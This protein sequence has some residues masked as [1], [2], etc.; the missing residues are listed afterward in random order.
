MK[1]RCLRLVGALTAL[2]A[3]SACD[4]DPDALSP[5]FNVSCPTALQGVNAPIE[6][7]FSGEVDPSTI[8][9]SNIVVSDAATG[10]ELPGSLARAGTGSTVRFTASDPL[11]FDTL[12]TVRFQNI[13]PAAGG[14]QLPVTICRIQ[15]EL[16]PIRELFWRRLPEAGGQPLLGAS[17]ADTAPNA[18]EFVISRLGVLYRRDGGNDVFI[19]G[20][21]RPDRDADWTVAAS[22]PYLSAG[23]DVDFVDRN[24]GFASFDDVRHSAG[25]VLRTRD[26]GGT[27]DT[28]VT[29]PNALTN[30]LLFRRTAGT[31][32]NDIFGML[33]GGSTANTGIRKYRPA[34]NS[35]SLVLASFGTG[36]GSDVDF[37][38]DTLQGV[39]STFGLRTGNLDIRGN[40]FRSSN[41]GESWTV[42]PGARATENVV[43]YRGTA[44]RN[45][46][47]A[48]VVGGNGFVGRLDVGATALAPVVVDPNLV[49]LDTLNVQAL[50]FNDI[51]FARDND[52][53][54]WIVG[55]RQIGIVGGLPQYQ[56][57][58]YV[59]RDG[60]VTWTRQGVLGA[61]QFGA[62]FPALNRL[63]VA[64]SRQALIVGDAGVVL[65][66]NP[67]QP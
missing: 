52:L 55:A 41:G 53:V 51:A 20:D 15:T 26:A 12:I 3:V 61:D 63:E 27:F 10:I 39:V 28:L 50:I 56:G 8:A 66:Y 2:G 37:T 13:L 54:G 1:I 18:L 4:N 47:T 23:L 46:G 31:A 42:I 24:L 45:N 60:G 64:S 22:V 32:P 67:P 62:E 7:T 38:S 34:T 5:A 43:T 58:I 25:R 57:L 33:V 19:P 6:F 17:L 44:I 16:P 65:K 29:T 35:V 14:Q 21:D 48:F 9:A 11:P 36:G 40:V 59:T 49:S 30:R